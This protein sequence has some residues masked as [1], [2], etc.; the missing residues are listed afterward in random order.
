MRSCSAASSMEF[1]MERNAVSVCCD[2][3]LYELIWMQQRNTN[4]F[5]ALVGFI[6]AACRACIGGPQPVLKGAF[7]E[8]QGSV[9]GSWGKNVPDGENTPSNA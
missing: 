3:A 7:S 2:Q 1:D 4:M 9:P 8:F 6:G 5:P